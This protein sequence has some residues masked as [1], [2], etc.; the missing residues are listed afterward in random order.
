MES[1]FRSIWTYTL[2]ALVVLALSVGAF[3][4]GGQGELTGQ[5]TDTTG[6]LVAGVEL[7]LT[8][9]ATGEVRTTVTTSA[10]TY[11]FP[12]LPIVGTYTLEI[13]AKGFKSVKIRDIVAS[14]GQTTTRDIKLEVGA[15]TEQV[16]VEAGAQMVQTEDTALSEN[17]DRRVWQ[18]MPLEDRSSNSFIGLLP[19]AEPAANAMLATDRGAAV[20]GT[21]SGAGNYMVE[22][23]DNNDQGLGG[24]GAIGTGPGGA[25]TSISPDAIE[26]Y[27]VIDSTPNAEYGKAGGFVADTVLKGGTN[28]WH[29][30]LFEYNRIQ[31]LAANSFFSNLAGDT[32]HL[33]RNQFG[34]SVGGPIIKDRTFFYFT[35][36]EQRLRVSSALSVNTVS[37]DFINFVNTGAFAAFMESGT[38]SNSNSTTGGECFNVLGTACPGA[39]STNPGVVSNAAL[40]P[41][42][43]Q[44]TTQMPIP[45]CV[46]G[47]RNCSNAAPAPAGGVPGGGLYTHFVAPINYPVNVYGT[48]NISQPETLN[49]TRYS[50]KV[51]HRL[52]SKDQ[53]SG[54]YLYDNSP[55]TTLYGGNNVFGP[56][57]YNNAKAQNA[58]VTWSHTFSPTILNQARM[59]YT[60]NTS[61]FPG[62]PRVQ[63]MPSTV[64]AFDSPAFGI[65]NAS[66]LPQFFTENLF[67]YKDDLSVTKGKHNFKGGAEY[68]RTRNGSSFD[69]YKY[70]YNVDYDIEDVLTDATF[71]NNLENV[72]GVVPTIFGAGATAPVYGSMYFTIASLNPTNGELPVYYRGYRANEAA[73]YIQDSWRVTSRLTANLGLRWEYFGPPHNFQPGLDGNF[74]T[75]SPILQTNPGNN[76]FWLPATSTYYAAFATGVDQQK[77]HDIW[78]KDLINYGPRVGF[79]YDVLGNQKAVVRGGFGINYDR[80]YNNIFENIRFNPPFFAAAELGA[81]SPGGVPITNALASGLVTN[82]FQGRSTFF[83]LPLTPELR[84]MDQNLKTAYYEQVHFGVQYQLTKDIVLE[85]NYVGTFG[86]QL[87]GVIGRNNYDGQFVGLDSTPIN[88]NYGAI[89][90]RTNCCD[91]NYHGWQTTLRKRFSNG[92]QFNVN[93]TYAKAMDDLSDAF[94]GKATSGAYPSDS[95][96]P[97]FDYGPADYDVRNRIVGSFVYDLPWMKSNRWIGGWNLS[98]I[99]SWQNGANFSI[100]NSGVDSNGDGVLNDRANYIGSGK[101]TN[102]INHNIGPWRGY[103]PGNNAD[104]SNPAFAFLN[105]AALPC[106][107]SVN[108]GLWCQGAALG[109]MM[110][111]TLVGPS[112]FNT[113]FGVKKTF[114]LTE[115]MGLRFEAN[116]F[117]LFNHPNFQ[118]PENNQADGNFGQSTAT[119]SNQQSGGPRITQLAARFD[120]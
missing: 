29:G 56:T 51:D 2:L 75:G 16:T 21:R 63:G 45:Y 22:G 79:A 60:R 93:Y 102:A 100:F 27:R 68:R 42:Y 19:G 99:V 52:T 26:E 54:T 119:Y 98:G 118:T 83:G 14:V 86:H 92:L 96:N 5:V 37:Q 53:L 91:S 72:P 116:F 87:I 50:T 1:S 120:F 38:P 69:A 43:S 3:A 36:E 15:A 66:N 28:Q 30:S 9:N 33:V 95:E 88:P 58:G 47:A 115:R 78:N 76:P 18:D 34:G 31:A 57:L 103:L 24:A 48:V 13:A 107:A 110:R 82:P 55:S 97:H 81:F 74:Y 80:M 113:D 67:T 44:E 46:T 117:N 101:I 111:N 61:N 70:G 108:M 17:I 90:F 65:G 12:A 71:S 62:D 25:N 73:A 104:G 39:F 109:Q 41:I 77:N 94:T 106:P 59:S 4:Q 32:D 105:T 8:Q 49:Q 40:G 84:A 20:N 112:F 89:N 85:S 114:K 11:N 6:A 35:V 7:K 64:T 23:F 10:G